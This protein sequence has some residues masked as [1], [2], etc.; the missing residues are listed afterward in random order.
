MNY[1]NIFQN[2]Q[3]LSVSVGNNYSEYQL[4]HIF[5]NN[6]HQDR[7]CSAQITSHQAELRREEKFT[8]Q[9]YLFISSLQTEYLNL[10]SSSGC[11]INIE[12]ENLVKKVY[13]LWRC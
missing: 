11:G 1:I 3:D 4:I 13:F 7:K 5:L 9:K 2:A 6:F 12:V 10:D 8:Y